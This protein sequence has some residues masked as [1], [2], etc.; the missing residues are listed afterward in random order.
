MKTILILCPWSSGSTAVAG[1]L[2]RCGGHTCP[3]HFS[4]NDPKTPNPYESLALSNSLKK[5]ID[6]ETPTLS[7]KE[8]KLFLK[9]SLANGLKSKK[10]WHKISEKRF[11]F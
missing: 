7:K 1:F 3:P 4:T 8:L 10:P 9:H 6:I 5:L 2:D 11:L